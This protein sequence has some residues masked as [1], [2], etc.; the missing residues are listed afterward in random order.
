MV[1]WMIIMLLIANLCYHLLQGWIA[2]NFFHYRR[3]QIALIYVQLQHNEITGFIVA[4]YDVQWV[5]WRSE[6]VRD[7]YIV[8]MQP[9]KQMCQF[10]PE[11]YKRILMR[12]S[13]RP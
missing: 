13:I 10:R 2:L 5:D 1:T 8:E 12:R 7:W 6:V 11:R 4:S 3:L 9:A